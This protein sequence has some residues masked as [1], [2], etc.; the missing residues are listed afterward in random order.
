MTT[1][2]HKHILFDAVEDIARL[3]KAVKADPP[4]IPN[5][6]PAWRVVHLSILSQQLLSYIQS[7]DTYR[8][9]YQPVYF[10]VASLDVLDPPDV[11]FLFSDART[12]VYTPPEVI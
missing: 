4:L 9:P 3:T 12:V 2:M 10:G 8:P 5:D 7:Y 1:P 11:K 6:V